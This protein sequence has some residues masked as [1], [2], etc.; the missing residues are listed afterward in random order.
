MNSLTEIVETA[1]DE[2]CQR[3]RCQKRGCRLGLPVL[4]KASEEGRGRQLLIDLDC[5]YL[6]IGGDETICDFLYIT[7]NNLV[8]V[9][10]LKGGDTKITDAQRQLQAGAQFAE[11]L[12]G[13]FGAQVQF[14]PVLGHGGRLR[15]QGRQ[16]HW[17]RKDRR[18]TG[19]RKTE[20]GQI[21]FNGE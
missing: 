18:R 20:A 15:G 7:D 3:K 2:R 8:V 1:L 4:T 6:A 16:K 19:Q 14:R 21:R 17:R 10:E 9:I 5:R 13:S 11:R 12:I